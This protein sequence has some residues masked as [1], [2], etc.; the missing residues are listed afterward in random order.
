MIQNNKNI[1]TRLV[2]NP[3]Y[4]NSLSILGNQLL[5]VVAGLAFW[6]LAARLYTAADVG[7]GSATTS[8]MILVSY[9]GLIGIDYALMRFLPINQEN[10][11]AMINTSMVLGSLTSVILAVIFIA[12]T[13]FWSPSLAFLQKEPIFFILFVLCT[14]LWSG[15]WIN[16]RVFTGKRKSHFALLQGVIFNG[17][18]LVL[19]FVFASIFNRLGVFLAWGLGGG[20][21]FLVGV[22]M[23]T[24]RV[25]EGYHLS[26]SIQ[27]RLVSP[28]IRYA[29]DNYVISLL[30]FG[31][32]YVMPLLVVNKLGETAN[33]YFFIAWQLANVIYAIPIAFSFSLT[34]EGAHEKADLEKNAR[35]SLAFSMGMVIIALLILVFFTRFLL[36]IFGAEYAENAS[37]MLR[38]AVIA[39]VPVAFNQLYFS[40]KRVQL[41]MGSTIAINSFTMVGSLLLSYY[42]LDPMGIAGTGVAWLIIHGV[43][44]VA[45][46]VLWFR[47]SRVCGIF[48]KSA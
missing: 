19:V 11:T 22:F 29:A 10:N 4:A 25:Q 26:L 31:A 47:E 5:L 28:M 20:I 27:K 48:G 23:F 33:A 16:S 6:L 30:W 3:L 7:I 32:L 40:V 17:F 15:Y 13:P 38:Y 24:P 43:A 14:G 39:G 18:R 45:V 21:A 44:A 2:T 36:G 35:R 8:A 37:T 12:G 1:L 41:K 42:L 9:F 46:F 34:V